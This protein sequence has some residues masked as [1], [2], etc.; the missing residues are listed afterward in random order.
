MFY[1]DAL[2]IYFID[3]DKPDRLFGNVRHFDC[4]R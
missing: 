1:V 3:P 2:L 4:N